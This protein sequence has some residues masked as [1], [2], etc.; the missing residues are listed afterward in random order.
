MKGITNS[1]NTKQQKYSGTSQMTETYPDIYTLPCSNPLN[2][3][4]TRRD[5]YG[6]SEVYF[7]CYIP[8][9]LN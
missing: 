8:Y 9:F 5:D 2:F 4:E 6:E 3:N 1:T 7:L